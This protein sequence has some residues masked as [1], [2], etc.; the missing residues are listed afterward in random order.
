MGVII[1]SIENKLTDIIRQDLSES[2][3]NIIIKNN[4]NKDNL[5]GPH[6]RTLIQIC[7][8]YGSIKCLNDLINMDYDINELEYSS[9]NSPLFIAC[10]FNYIEIVYLLLNN[11]RQKC[12]TLRKNNEGLNEFEV[13]FLRGNYEICYYLLYEYEY[14]HKQE[15]AINNFLLLERN[16][17]KI[18]D[19]KEAKQDHTN[20]N[21]EY[22]ENSNEYLKFFNEKNFC[23]EKYLGIQEYLSYPLFNMPLFYESLKK[24]KMP[25]ENP[26]FEFERKKTKDL[27][28]KIPD[29]NETWSNFMKRLAN[30]ELYNPPLIDKR[31]FRKT[32]SL[33]MKTQMKIIS[34]EYG[35]KMDYCSP[36][37]LIVNNNGK[38]YDNKD[39]EEKDLININYK[40]KN[41]EEKTKNEINDDELTQNKQ[42]FK[43][44]V[45]R[46]ENRINVKS[47][48]EKI[49]KD[50]MSKIKFYTNFN[51][52]FDNTD[53]DS[54]KKAISF[55]IPVKGKSIF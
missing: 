49:I 5:I 40:E 25:G 11:H 32:N 52:Y 31:T 6:K 24:K 34:M 2:M 17:N 21:N 48:S 43:I 50:K 41:D 51:N 38:N 30:L 42:Y 33:Y 22:N 1:P 55:T 3:K 7:A 46:N 14:E 35:I 20:E 47:K 18:K 44:N 19:S 28:T 29:P 36:E 54:E 23:L 9:N 8:Y 10:K 39:E 16:K 4:I 26:S 15:K 13:A 37:D 12:I 27:L 53:T 45:R